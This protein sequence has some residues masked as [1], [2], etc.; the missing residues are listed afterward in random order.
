MAKTKIAVVFGGMSNE[1]EVALVSAAHVIRSIPRD[2]YDVTCIGITQKG[3]WLQFIG[4]T[5]L[6]PT[7]EW[8]KHTDNVPCV[9]SPDPLHKGFLALLSDGTV[10]FIKIDIVFPVIHGKNG[11]DGTIQG[12]MKLAKMPFVGCDTVSSANCMDKEFTHI[13]LESAGIPMAKYVAVTK[14]ELEHL[15]R[16]AMEITEVLDFPM[17]V[18]PANAG[19][20]VGVTKAH[21][22]EELLKGIRLAFA[23]DAKV[24][25]EQGI[26]G[27][28]CECAVLGNDAP[29]ASTAGEI[30]PENEFYDYEAKYRSAG[31]G[32][33]IPARIPAEGIEKIRLTALKAFAAIDCKGLARIDFFYCEDGSIYLNEINTMP[34]F[35]EISMYPKLM[36]ETGLSQ[37]ELMDQLIQLG[38]ER[39]EQYE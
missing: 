32:L 12:L 34:G 17:F 37:P 13:I 23:H 39:S 6:I 26:V 20:S 27:R 2:K 33:Y 38:L 5:K 31:G 1:Y 11:E 16:R 36:G 35:T 29:V 7:G 8:E 18:K 10:Q 9:L 3:H 14:P 19:S 15:E 4:D 22:Y 25:V 21:N 24:L 28:E 30:V